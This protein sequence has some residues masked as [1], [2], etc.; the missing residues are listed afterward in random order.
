MSKRKLFLIGL[1]VL[2]L[3]LIL[4]GCGGATTPAPA[5]TN[6][7]ATQPTTAAA[8]AAPPAPKP[9]DVV[10][11][12]YPNPP[13]NNVTLTVVGDAGQNLAPWTFW[14]DE[15]AKAGITIKVVEVPFDG[16]YEKEKA[17]FVAGSGAFDIVTF[18]PTYIGDFAGNGYLEPLDSYMQ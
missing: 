7:P 13:F 5:A 12:D 2:T 14:K 9:L 4:M 16:V 10:K 17:E 8:P 3:G 15:L 11:W 18:Y 6:A 1:T